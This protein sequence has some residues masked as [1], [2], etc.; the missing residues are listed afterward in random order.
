MRIYRWRGVDFGRNYLL[1]L[2]TGGL[3]C[4]HNLYQMKTRNI[5]ALIIILIILQSCG[6]YMTPY[7]AANHPRGRRCATIR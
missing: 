2:Q 1:L 3:S 6:K 7:E 4:P 5:L